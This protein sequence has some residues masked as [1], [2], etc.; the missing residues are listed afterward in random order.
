MRE[1]HPRVGKLAR[2]SPP[3]RSTH[4]T[5]R[6]LA[7][8]PTFHRVGKLARVSPP[9]RSTHPNTRVL[10]NAPTLLLVLPSVPPRALCGSPPP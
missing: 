1:P 4:P 6:L 7:N 8:A 2:V 9:Q 5:A 10:A 3:Q